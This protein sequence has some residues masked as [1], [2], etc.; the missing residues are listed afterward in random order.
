MA[1]SLVRLL[2]IRALATAFTA[3]LALAGAVH[4]QTFP[5]KPVRLVVPFGPGGSSDVVARIVADGAGE[6]H[7]SGWASRSGANPSAG[8][9]WSRPTTSRPSSGF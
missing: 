6:A 8:P 3:G 4:A 5:G 9:R 1:Y 2:F 7:P